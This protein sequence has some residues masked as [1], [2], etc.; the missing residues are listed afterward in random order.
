MNIAYQGGRDGFKAMVL[1]V[2]DL[3]LDIR[4]TFGVED[5]VVT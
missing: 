2:P 4:D 3:A 5:K 1:G